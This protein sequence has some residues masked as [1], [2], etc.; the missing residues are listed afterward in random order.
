MV[1]LRPEH[2]NVRDPVADIPATLQL[3]MV[4]LSGPLAEIVQT[5]QELLDKAGRG[6]LSAS[7]MTVIG[8]GA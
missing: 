8:A 3:G 4:F 7:F 5:A 6:E 2:A 1:F